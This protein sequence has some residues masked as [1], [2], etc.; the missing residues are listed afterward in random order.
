MHVRFGSPGTKLTV[1]RLEEIANYFKLDMIDLLT[2][3]KKYIPESDLLNDVKVPNKTKVQL[4]LEI[5][6]DKKEQILKLL[7]GENN[8]EFFK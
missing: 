4:Q 8:L 5:D 6:E 7:F 1:D 3:P 2:Y